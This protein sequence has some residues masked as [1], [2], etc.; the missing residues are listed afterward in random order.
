MEESYSF[1]KWKPGRESSPA[2]PPASRT[3]GIVRLVGTLLLEHMKIGWRE[4]G[5]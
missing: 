2:L 5:I 4:G 1:G 3:G